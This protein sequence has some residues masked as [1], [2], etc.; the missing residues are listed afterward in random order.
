LAGRNSHFNPK[1]WSQLDEL[2]KNK[3]VHFTSISKL[4]EKES[5]QG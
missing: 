2:I 5:G 1:P 4:K 3:E